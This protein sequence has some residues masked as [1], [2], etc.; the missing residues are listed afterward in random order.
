MTCNAVCARMAAAGVPPSVGGQTS[1]GSW[2]NSVTNPGSSRRTPPRSA[3]P[4]ARSRR[5]ASGSQAGWTILPASGRS[6]SSPVANSGCLDVSAASDRAA[7]A[8]STAVCTV[9]S[10]RL[11][12]TARR[13]SY[14]ITPSTPVVASGTGISC[15]DRARLVRDTRLPRALRSHSPTAAMAALLVRSHRSGCAAVRHSRAT[16]ARKRSCSSAASASPSSTK[17]PAIDPPP[18]SATSSS[19]PSSAESLKLTPS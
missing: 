1:N 14:S 13:R 10:S 6:N 17:L 19:S 4:M 3:V 12:F 8:V 15:K 5:N 16:P 2:R 9:S 18:P 11:P 7:A